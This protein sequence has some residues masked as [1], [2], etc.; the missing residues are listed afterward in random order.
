MSRCTRRTF[1]GKLKLQTKRRNSSVEKLKKF[2]ASF[3]PY[4]PHRLPC[5]GEPGFNASA[6]P[7]GVHGG[8]VPCTTKDSLDVLSFFGMMGVG[9][10]AQIRFYMFALFHKCRVDFAVMGEFINWDAGSTNDAV[11]AVLIWS[12]LALEWLTLNEGPPRRATHDGAVAQSG[13]HELSRW[14]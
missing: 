6:I 4:D 9:S 3:R 14:I 2:R 12:F 10:T 1:L 8:V 13:R 11:W 7:I 5:F